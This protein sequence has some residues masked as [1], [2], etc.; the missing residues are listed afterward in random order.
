MASS[1]KRVLCVCRDC[2]WRARERSG[3]AVSWLE[4][5]ICGKQPPR[6]ER[7]PKSQSE[8]QSE[9]D[10][11]AAPSH[12]LVS[13]PHPK[14]IPRPSLCLSLIGISMASDHKAPAQSHKSPF[15]FRTPIRLIL[16]S[17]D[18]HLLAAFALA[19]FH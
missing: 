10:T 1:G 9:R 3:V 18:S 15:R 11:F 7:R 13:P 8:Q 4:N 17:S 14:P 16:A 6:S 2:D 5:S 12:W 19:F